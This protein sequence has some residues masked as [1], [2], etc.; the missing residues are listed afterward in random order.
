MFFGL[1]HLLLYKMILVRNQEKSG[2]KIVRHPVLA[3]SDH[4]IKFSLVALL[5][6]FRPLMLFYISAW[7]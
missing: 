4:F 6:S 7:F 1:L 5:S 2:G 3:L